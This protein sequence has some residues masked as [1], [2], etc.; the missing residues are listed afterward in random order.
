MKDIYEL[1]ELIK[2]LLQGLEMSEEK[3]EAFDLLDARINEK[4]DR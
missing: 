3:K 1:L 2:F 4:L